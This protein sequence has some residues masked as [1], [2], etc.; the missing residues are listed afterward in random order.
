VWLS[1]EEVD[2]TPK[3]FDLLEYLAS[4]PSQVRSREDIVARV[5]DEHWWGPTETLDAHVAALR[6]KLGG[7]ARITALRGVGYRLDPPE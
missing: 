1:G 4:A 3:E 2:L 6:R 7:H 5:W